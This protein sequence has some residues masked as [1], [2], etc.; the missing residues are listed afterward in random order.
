V[1]FDTNAARNIKPES[2]PFLYPGKNHFVGCAGKRKK[3]ECDNRRKDG[4]LVFNAE[5]RD[6]CYIG[7]RLW[8]GGG[9]SS[10]NFQKGSTLSREGRFRMCHERGG[11][12]RENPIKAK[13]LIAGV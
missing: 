2:K 7:H 8:T 4:E 10:G 9:D 3:E 6:P 12:K 13:P 1:D 5:E 11:G